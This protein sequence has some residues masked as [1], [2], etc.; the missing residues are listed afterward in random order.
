MHQGGLAAAGWLCCITATIPRGCT[1][2]GNAKSRW[3]ALSGLMLG[4]AKDPD[5]GRVT[6]CEGR[7]MARTGL[8][9]LCLVFRL[10]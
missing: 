9:W 10:S 2:E 8:R 5:L 1:V 4:K 6:C 3:K 7:L